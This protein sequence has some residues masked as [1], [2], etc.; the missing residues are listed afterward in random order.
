MMQD[1]KTKQLIGQEL[2]DSIRE[3]ID[4]YNTIL[5]IQIIEDN[6]VRHIARWISF[7]QG[8]KEKMIQDHLG[9]V[10]KN[11]LQTITQI[12]KSDT[13]MRSETSNDVEESQR[14]ESDNML[15]AKELQDEDIASISIAEINK[16]ITQD[17]YLSLY[18][19]VLGE[20]ISSLDKKLDDLTILIK[21]IKADIAKTT[22]SITTDVA[23]TSKR[24]PLVVFTYIQRPLEISDFK[25]SS[26]KNLEDLLDQK[27]SD[28]DIQELVN[29]KP[30]GL[31]LKPIDLSQDIANG[32]NTDDFKNYGSEIFEWNLDGLIDR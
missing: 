17:N 10:R 8:D 1:P 6:S 18:V 28:F 3:K 22:L 15:S 5:P 26:L 24:K 4:H 21:H 29:K 25:L 27:F 16:L 32:M 31:D 2:L 30:V 13:S 19:N 11:L 7:Q 20:H 14:A 12:D 9:E 23:S